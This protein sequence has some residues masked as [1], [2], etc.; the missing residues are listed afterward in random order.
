VDMEGFRHFIHGFGE[1][2]DNCGFVASMPLL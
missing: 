1:S 2:G